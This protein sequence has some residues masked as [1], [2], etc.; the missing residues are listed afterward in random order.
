ME[1]EENFKLVMAFR[2][3]L[4]GKDFVIFILPLLVGLLLYVCLFVFLD[5]EAH[6]LEGYFPM[7]FPGSST[8]KEFACNAGDPSLIPESGRSLEKG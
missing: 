3:H 2:F 4:S 7:G 5:L 6:N 8:G 1:P